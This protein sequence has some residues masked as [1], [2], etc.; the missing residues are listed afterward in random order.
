MLVDSLGPKH[1]SLANLTVPTLVIGS[2]ED[3][4]LPI[5]ASRRIAK[6]APNLA[7]F[8]ELPGGHCSNLERP[9]EVNKHLRALIESVERRIIA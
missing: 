9:D 7:A 6:Y 1:I 8:V 4:L 3:R 2:R 5:S